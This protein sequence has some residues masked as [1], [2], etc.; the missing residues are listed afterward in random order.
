[1]KLIQHVPTI[2]ITFCG[3]ITNF[4]YI[5]NH[6]DVDCMITYPDENAK[7]KLIQF[8]T[9]DLLQFDIKK[10]RHRNMYFKHPSYS[11]EFQ[12]VY[13]VTFANED[14]IDLIL[15]PDHIG[16]LIKYQ[17]GPGIIL[18][19]CKYILTWLY[20]HEIISKATC[21]YLKKHILF[22]IRDGYLGI[23]THFSDVHVLKNYNNPMHYMHQP[24]PS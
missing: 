1:M 20:I 18:L 16:P 24:N 17:K 6:S 23:T 2:D 11:D 22:A 8:I 5:E 7:M 9:D 14:E 4:T 10:I 13:S 3:S 15:I 21:S 12:D 19:C